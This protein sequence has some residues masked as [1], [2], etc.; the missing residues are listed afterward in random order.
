MHTALAELNLTRMQLAKA[1]V[2]FN[3]V[4]AALHSV[5]VADDRL[6]ATA[7]YVAGRVRRVDA[8]LDRLQAMLP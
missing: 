2:L 8:Q 5:G 6:A 1:G 7:A 4:V 3:Q